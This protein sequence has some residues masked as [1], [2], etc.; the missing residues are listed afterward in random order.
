MLE[1]ARMP[2][3]HWY[4]SKELSLLLCYFF[5]TLENKKSETIY[6]RGLKNGN[7]LQKMSQPEESCSSRQEYSSSIFRRRLGKIMGVKKKLS[8]AREMKRGKGDHSLRV[9]WVGESVPLEPLAGTGNPPWHKHAPNTCIYN[10]ANWRCS[11]Q[12]S[13]FFFILVGEQGF[14]SRFLN[15]PCLEYERDSTGNRFRWVTA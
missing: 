15:F 10:F 7:T 2:S 12:L 13:L 8:L 11:F 5:F 1:V 6:N 3:F 9:T 14:S 4:S